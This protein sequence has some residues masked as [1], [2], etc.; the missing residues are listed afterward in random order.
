LAGALGHP[1]LALQQP[2]EP[3]RAAQLLA[4]DFDVRD[5]RGERVMPAVWVGLG[6]VRRGLG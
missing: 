3:A 6:P 1:Q 4:D 2:H 5:R